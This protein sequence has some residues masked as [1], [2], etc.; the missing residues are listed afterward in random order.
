M[1]KALFW[2]VVG[3]A[4]ALQA[5]RL[6]SKQKGRLASTSVTGRLLDAT[7]R[8]LEA[9]RGSDVPPGPGTSPLG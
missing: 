2:T 6:V 8:K 4:G 3:A 9:K 1:I 5:D 7:N